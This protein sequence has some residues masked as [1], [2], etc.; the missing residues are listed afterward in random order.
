MKRILLVGIVFALTLGLLV[1]C[2]R[3]DITITGGDIIIGGQQQNES[4][5][6]VAQP[7]ALEQSPINDNT[8]NLSGLTWLLLIAGIPLSILGIITLYAL[9]K[10]IK[11]NN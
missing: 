9:A 11:S 2:N 7:T 6:Y 8:S 1:S 4:S 10:K 5:T 3:N